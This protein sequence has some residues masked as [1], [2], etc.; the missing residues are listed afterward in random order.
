MDIETLSTKWAETECETLWFKRL[1]EHLPVFIKS[2]QDDLGVVQMQNAAR[3]AVLMWEWLYKHD[4]ALH[5]A[6]LTYEA[7]TK[8]H[9]DLV[10]SMFYNISNKCQ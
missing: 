3:Y 10:W 8:N 2:A 6:L 1:L 9:D 5:D 4:N 7:E